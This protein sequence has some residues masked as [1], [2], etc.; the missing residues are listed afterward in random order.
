MLRGHALMSILDISFPFVMH[1]LCTR[2]MCCSDGSDGG[3]TDE[4]HAPLVPPL[5]T[6][7]PTIAPTQPI[8]HGTS[9]SLA[10]HSNLAGPSNWQTRATAAAAGTAPSPSDPELAF[11]RA[12]GARNITHGITYSP[13]EASGAGAAAATPAAPTPM[14]PCQDD[15]DDGPVPMSTGETQQMAAA[16]GFMADAEGEREW[17][18]H[19]PSPANTSV[20]ASAA[21]AGSDQVRFWSFCSF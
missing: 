19:V 21:N 7:V 17:Q 11:A 2:V 18:P 12:H 8:S 6:V 1:V 4:E 14:G 15:E 13:A 9:L 3:T 5:A 16:L 20:A 10:G